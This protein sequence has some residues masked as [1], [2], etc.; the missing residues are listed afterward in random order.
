MPNKISYTSFSLLLILVWGCDNK[1]D[2][3]AEDWAPLFNGKDLTGWDIKIAGQPLNDNYKNTFRWEDSMLRVSYE[4][5]DS[6]NNRFGHMYYNTPYSYYKLKFQ[7]RIV[8]DHLPDAPGWADKNSGIMV[9]SQS[10]QSMNIDQSFPVSLEMQLLEGT[11]KGESTTGN[12]CTPGTQVHINGILM[13]DHCISS[14]SKK[15]NGDQWVSGMIEVY[16]D[17]LIRHI[18][19]GDTVLTYTNTLIGGGF[20]DNSYTWAKANITDSVF[21]IKKAGTPLKEGY[22]ALQAESQPVDFRKVELLNLAG[23]MD[24]KA[25]NYKDYYIKQDNSK[26]KY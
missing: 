19:N 1:K 15:Y 3:S 9:H 24:P 20:V 5:Y 26:C 11:R 12:I 25:K 2:K 22:I 6:F 14:S 13:Q 16:G 10:A 17:S 4:K 23:C 18:I 8:G 7:Y 21:W